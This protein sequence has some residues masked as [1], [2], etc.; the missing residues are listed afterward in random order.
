MQ[1]D[2]AGGMTA[3]VRTRGADPGLYVLV[4]MLRWHSISAD[5]E[6]IR[7]RFGRAA[8]GISEMLLCAKEFGLK[9]RERVINWDRLAT[10]P[11][12][13]IAALRDGGYLLLAKAADG[14]VLVAQPHAA[15]PALLNQAELEAI[16]DG[17]VV[18]MTRRAGL[19]ELSR[20][21]DINWFLGAI[22]KYRHQLF[23]V[24]ATSFFLQLFALVTPLFFQVVIDKVLVHR[25]MSTLDVLVIGLVTI[26]I[27]ETILGVLR[28]YLFA[29]TTNRIDVELG[30]RLFRHLLA[31]PIAYFGARRVGDSVARVRELENIRNFLTSS[32][33]TLVIDLFFTFVFLAV[34][35]IYSP[36][37]TFVVLAAFPFYIGISAGATPLFRRR[38]D[39]KFRR[40]AENQAFLV[41]S[42]T[43]VETLKAMAVEPQIQRRWEEQLAGYVAAS[44]RVL[45]LANTASQS[46]QLV[47][48][49]VTVGV[50]YFGAKLVIDN[51]LTV[52]ELVAFNIMAGRV[53]APV[54]RI[55]QMWQD[56]HQARLSVARLGDILNTQPE[57]TFN[58]ARA[59]LPTIRGEIA[60]EH[61]TFRYRVDGPE[62]LHDVTFKIGPGQMIG[63]VGASG[64]GKSTL[65]K[66]IQRL[67]VPESGRV[68]V[69][70]IDLAMIDPAWLRRQ[71]GVVLQ[72]N[73]LFNCSIRDNIALADP[74]LPSE[75]IISA[76]KLAGA[77]DF[78]LELPEAYD[79]IVGERGDTLSG[80]QRQR[81][82]IAR[83]LITDPRILIFDEATSA[84]DYESERIIQ[85]N[86][87]E[88]AENRTVIIVAHRL[89]TLRR[90]GRILTI[91][92]GRLVEEGTH[93]ELI[94]TGGNYAT[95]HRLQAGIHEV[96]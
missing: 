50:L 63:I 69:D 49:L 80:G 16:W 93:D 3:E 88:I 42:V 75:R 95:L 47:S 7:H 26:S 54:L 84:L 32:A 68:L 25:S 1:R 59:A 70:G 33:L 31:L 53:S 73:I 37:L 43:G 66:L 41:E 2:R 36:L 24:L 38:L 23:E 58:T 57:P 29:H 5:P 83:A 12:P 14:K 71:I 35:F 85:E 30:A 86:M 60:F 10:M 40:G 64:S 74:A 92:R 9:A 55:A 13:A 79:T 21:F 82:A 17:R 90:T 15:R 76:A 78:I 67:Y 18:L 4:G 39:E 27:F 22:H 65:T 56:F 51:D 45:Q 44:F 20:R 91:D 34:M 72:E 61:V 89:S 11:L 52:G 8:I 28:T 46:V 48:R 94:R 87:L 77:H 19:A 62:V 81:I 6:Q 96:R